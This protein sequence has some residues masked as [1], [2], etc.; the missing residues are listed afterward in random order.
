MPEFTTLFSPPPAPTGLTLEADLFASVIRLEWNATAI[1]PEDFAGYTVY[2]RMGDMTDWE[3]YAEASSPMF[4]D[5]HAPLNTDMSYRVTQ[6]SVDYES[7][8]A[9]ASTN[10]LR[11]KRW[12]VVDEHDMMLTFPIPKVRAATIRSPKVMESYSPIGRRSKIAVSD[13]VQD[14]EITELRF[15]MMPDDPHLAA[16]I[17]AAQAR[18]FGYV[19]IKAPDGSMFHTQ[20]SDMTRSFTAVEGL[21]EITLSAVSAGAV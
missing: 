16:M 14:E 12:W 17:R 5:F 11:D 2:R 20:L 3:E 21:Q 1:P 4:E 19:M 10:G 7:G 9:E 18:T 6:S 15:L 13:V 8:P